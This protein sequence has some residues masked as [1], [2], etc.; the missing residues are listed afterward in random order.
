MSNTSYNALVSYVTKLRL[1]I[2]Y[3]NISILPL[4][5]HYYTLHVAAPTDDYLSL[6][7]VQTPTD[8]ATFLSL[9]ALQ[10]DRCPTIPPYGTSIHVLFFV[11]HVATLHSESVFNAE[12]SITKPTSS[13][14]DGS[15]FIHKF[16]LADKGLRKGDF[17]LRIDGCSDSNAHRC[18]VMNYT[19]HAQVLLPFFGGEIPTLFVDSSQFRFS[20]SFPCSLYIGTFPLDC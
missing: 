16:F 2:E 6:H 7:V 8:E 19:M 12:V 20:F 13:I 3:R 18:E 9:I 4:Q 5:R 17:F 10:K 15:S 11:L 1:G 14:R